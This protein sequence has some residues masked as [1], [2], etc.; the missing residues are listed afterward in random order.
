MNPLETL[1]EQGVS[2]W[3]D[4]LSR[5]RINSGSLAALI[6]DSHV[7][8]VTTNPSIFSNAVNS[9]DIYTEQ[10][11]ELRS[12]GFTT[13]EIVTEL[14]TQDV[15]NACDL[16]MGVYH[17]THGVDGRVS[18]EVEPDL[19]YDTGRTI[20]RGLALWEKVNRP[21]LLI[22]VPA[23]I[24]G[25]PAIEELTARGVSVN[26]TLIFSPERYREVLDAYMRGL[27]RRQGSGKDLSSIHSVASFFV[28]R[29]DTAIDSLLPSD[30]S[31]RGRMAI[32]NARL[33]YEI[34]LQAI[35]TL[36]WQKL[37]AGGA[38]MQRPL[39]AST[40]VKDKNYDPTRYV[41]ELIAPHCVN[42]MP[43]G[44][45]N[46]VR[47]QGI[48][49]GNTITSHLDESRECFDALAKSGVNFSHIVSSLEDDGVK[50]FADA[51]NELLTKVE[52]NHA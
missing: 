37:A 9:S 11:Q 13:S 48:I 46:A 24:E 34:F 3:L 23:T 44:T 50:K 12:K 10:I 31:L 39:W 4:D 42:T 47:N 27:E 36:R 43:E 2:I 19:A 8:G 40:G 1:S 49:T 14:T 35:S 45:L 26:V 33:A 30:S 21:N 38:N 29:I 32:A 18:I 25:L 20:D 5:D 28:S 15:A 17:H 7:V 22:K 51:W 52:S 16:F 6:D 41:V